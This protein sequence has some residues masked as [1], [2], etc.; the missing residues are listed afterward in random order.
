MY[1]CIL[2]LTDKLQKR[3]DQMQNRKAS[4]SIFLL[5]I[6]FK[7][8]HDIFLA[9]SSFVPTAPP[10]A[11]SQKREEEEGEALQKQ[12]GRADACNAYILLIFSFPSRQY[13]LVVQ[14]NLQYQFKQFIS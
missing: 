14:F 5:V 2:S 8:I 13:N 10:L 1:P 12:K 3:L 6:F 9:F 4:R 11:S 7:G